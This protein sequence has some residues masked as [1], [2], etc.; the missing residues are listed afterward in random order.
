MFL[1]S[2]L[3][4][5]SS[6]TQNVIYSNISQDKLSALHKCRSTGLQDNPSARYTGF[7]PARI[8]SWSS[9][10]SAQGALPKEED[11]QEELVHFEALSDHH[12]TWKTCWGSRWTV[13]AFINLSLA[14]GSKDEQ[15]FEANLMASKCTN[16]SSTQHLCKHS[17]Q[18][19]VWEPTALRWPGRLLERQNLRP[20][21][22]LKRS[23]LVFV[24]SSPGYLFAH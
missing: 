1:L 14:P 6:E 20:N 7:S 22:R 11:F 9:Q 4:V 5:L 2:T 17:T 8:T 16:T 15:L 10:A 12:R 13:R 23:E 3:W 19:L 18:T 24:T 21:P